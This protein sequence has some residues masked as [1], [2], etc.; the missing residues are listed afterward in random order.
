[1]NWIDIKKELPPSG[2]RVLGSLST[3]AIRIITYNEEI[4]R[5]GSIARKYRD[6]YR[7]VKSED[8]EAWMHLPERFRSEEH[9]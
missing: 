3:G 7:C 1:M 5:S 2:V 8:I 4:T 9:N 6:G